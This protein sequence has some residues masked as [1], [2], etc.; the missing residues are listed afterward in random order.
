MVETVADIFLFLRLNKKYCLLHLKVLNYE[1]MGF[2]AIW[3]SNLNL[4]IS[5]DLC[6]T[7]ISKNY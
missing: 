5:N 2:L 3:I 6:C 4:M 7:C 1:K